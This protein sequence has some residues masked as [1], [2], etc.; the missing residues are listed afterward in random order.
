MELINNAMNAVVQWTLIG[1]S[2]GFCLLCVAA[3]WKWFFGVMRK[4]LRYLFPGMRRKKNTRSE[5]SKGEC[6]RGEYYDE[7]GDI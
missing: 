4:A 2:A 1:V 5:Y 6:A 7:S 3:I